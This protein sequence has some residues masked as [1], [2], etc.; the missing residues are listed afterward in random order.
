MLTNI[1]EGGQQLH[2]LRDNMPFGQVG[3]GLFGTYFIGYA[4]SPDRIE[5]MLN[6]M[7]LGSLDPG[8]RRIEAG[9]G[10]FAVSALVVAAHHA[11]AD[12]LGL[13]RHGA[14]GF[15]D[16]LV[17]VAAQLDVLAHLLRHRLAGLLHGLVAGRVDAL[18]NHFGRAAG[19]ALGGHLPQARLARRV[20]VGKG[21]W[22][23]Q[24]ERQGDQGI[25]GGTV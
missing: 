22:G 3:K 10:F 1:E 7:F 15:N 16:D 17:A 23:H 25:G 9:F 2:I 4:R 12:H 19:A 13:G 11:A 8:H 21:G 20:V 14:S 24:A 5:K 18:V 6:N